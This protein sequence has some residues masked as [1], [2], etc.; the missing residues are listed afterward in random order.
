I[1]TR[2]LERLAEVARSEGI[3]VF[4][5][6]VMGENRKM[7]QVFVDSGFDVSQRIHGGVYH[8][9]LSLEATPDYSAKA[10]MRS[11]LAPPPSQKPFFEPSGV[12]VVGA[13]RERGRIG[14]EIFHNL[15]ASGFAGTVI[16]VH[17]D[18]TAIEGRPVF[19]RVSDIPGSVDLAVIV[20]PAAQ[21]LGAID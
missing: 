8:V 20:I 14:S 1:G 2:L 15:I 7:M 9:E 18:V 21:V 10:A 11:Q 17:P 12:A 16:P 3:R 6:E 13:Y 5:A 19:A 4:D